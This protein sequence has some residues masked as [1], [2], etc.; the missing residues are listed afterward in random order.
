[1]SL[2]TLFIFLLANIGLVYGS[3]PTGR[4]HQTQG[5]GFGA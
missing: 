4:L 1:M 3:I 5:K 2:Q